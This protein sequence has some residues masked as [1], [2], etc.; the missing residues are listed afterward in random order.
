MSYP[1]SY[2]ISMPLYNFSSDVG[3]SGPRP[4]SIDSNEDIHHFLSGIPDWMNINQEDLNLAL[5]SFPFPLT[6]P[7]PSGISLQEDI[8]VY[9][10]HN[11][12]IG[13][14]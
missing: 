12:H 10:R 9:Q 13:H 11:I 7:I 8:Q 2:T 3:A 6:G 5:E 14:H 1:T 4:P